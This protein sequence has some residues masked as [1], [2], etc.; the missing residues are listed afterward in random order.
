MNI[1]LMKL[2]KGVTGSMSIANLMALGGVSAQQRVAC[3][4]PPNLPT[5]APTHPHS[6][7]LCT[8]SLPGL[9]PNLLHA[10]GVIGAK[11]LVWVVTCICRAYPA[12]H[13]AKSPRGRGPVPVTCHPVGLERAVTFALPA[14]PLLASH[15]MHVLKLG[16][17]CA[18]LPL[19]TSLLGENY[20]LGIA[21]FGVSQWNFGN[22]RNTNPNANSNVLRCAAGV[23][24]LILAIGKNVGETPL[25]RMW[26]KLLAS[27][28]GHTCLRWM[29]GGPCTPAGLASL[30][31][32]GCMVALPHPQAWHT[33]AS[34]CQ[35]QPF[36]CCCL[37]PTRPA[38]R[39][40]LRRLGMV[41]LMKS[42]SSG[43][44]IKAGECPQQD[45]SMLCSCSVPVLCSCL[46][47]AGS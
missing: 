35:A 34:L 44:Y 17:A 45:R 20:A 24:S 27:S 31:C 26:G 9:A 46:A 42:G 41:A 28:L 16:A 8:P 3:T 5:C 2:D 40:A 14:F 36:Q 21:G 39:A 4:P 12:C 7:P 32:G 37:I 33:P 30:V 19:Q 29:H 13:P 23:I 22:L 18:P 15:I 43:T 6:T 11:E 47:K 38:C 1:G 25:E 10:M